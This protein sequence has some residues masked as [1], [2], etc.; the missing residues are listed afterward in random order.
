VVQRHLDRGLA[1]EQ[2]RAAQHLEQQHAGAVDVGAQV[3]R[4]PRTC[5]GLM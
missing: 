5:S 3:Q 4:R 2:V 1:V